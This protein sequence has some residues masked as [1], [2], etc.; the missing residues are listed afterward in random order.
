MPSA[1]RDNAGAKQSLTDLEQ[2]MVRYQQA[3]PEAPRA[4]IVGLSPALLR[5]FRSQVAIREQADDLLQETWLRI[6]RVRHTYR[7]GEPVLP[8]VYAIARR[9]GIDGYRRTRRITSHESAMDVLPEQSAHAGTQSTIPAFDALVAVLPETQREVVTMMKVG[10]LSL[11]EVARATSCTVGAV[12]QKAHRAYEKLRKLLEAQTAEGW[13]G[14]I[15]EL[16]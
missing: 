5:F 13:K 1:L 6:H 10:G 4:L 3:D 2:W 15:D 9:V 7:P 16:R 8:W 11:E 12:K 14:G